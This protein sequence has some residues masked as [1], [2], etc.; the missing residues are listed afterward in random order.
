L[1]DANPIAFDPGPRFFENIT[2]FIV[3][4][5]EADILQNMEHAIE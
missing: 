1:R 5:L 2:G 3:M 4:Y